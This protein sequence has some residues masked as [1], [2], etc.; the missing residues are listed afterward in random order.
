MVKKLYSTMD[1]PLKT[2]LALSFNN[3]IYKS[4]K[5]STL[6]INDDNTSI[7]R[8]LFI[9]PEEINYSRVVRIFI[10]SIYNALG[11]NPTMK[12]DYALSKRS[13]MAYEGL[14]QNPLNLF[15]SDDLNYWGLPNNELI[16]VC[17]GLDFHAVI[18]LNPDFNPFASTLIKHIKANIKI[19]YYSKYAEKYYNILIERKETDFLE[20][21][22]SYILQLLGVK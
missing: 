15:S 8:V 18:D 22:N 3:V 4:I 6:G 1:F 2:R 20:R 11:P 10:Q 16:N 19:G 14:I 17:K 5:N 12:I 7:S 9:L 21:G 13:L